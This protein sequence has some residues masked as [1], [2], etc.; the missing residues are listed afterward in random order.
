M[1]FLRKAN[2]CL[3]HVSFLLVF[4][5]TEMLIS[6]ELVVA[7]SPGASQLLPSDVTS[8]IH[9]NMAKAVVQIT[10]LCATCLFFVQLK[11]SIFTLNKGIG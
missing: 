6:I 7:A 1:C 4:F 2:W 3:P 8:L 5:G 11:L 10:S 9:R